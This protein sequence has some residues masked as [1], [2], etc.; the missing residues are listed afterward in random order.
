MFSILGGVNSHVISNFIGTVEDQDD[1]YLDMPLV[2][3]GV[4]V[5]RC[6]KLPGSCGSR[7]VMSPGW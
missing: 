6:S 3:P 2:S 4:K 5:F 1:E 7:H